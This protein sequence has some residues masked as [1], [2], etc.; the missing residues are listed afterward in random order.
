MKIKPFKIAPE[1]I[2]CYHGGVLE[3]NAEA[4]LSSLILKMR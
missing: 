2:V 1:I 3:N 4:K